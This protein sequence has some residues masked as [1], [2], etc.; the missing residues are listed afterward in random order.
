MFGAD[1]L[2]LTP[3]M[4]W[5]SWNSMQDSVTQAK[6][7]TAMSKLAEKRPWGLDGARASLADLGY[8]T[9][10]LDDAWQACGTGVNGSFHDGA[11]GRPLVNTSKFPEMGAMVAKAHALGLRAGFYINNCICAENMWRGADAFSTAMAA[12]VFEGTAAQVL[13][14]GFDGVKIDSCSQFS[15]MTR[16]AELFA[17]GPQT[18]LLEDCHDSDLQDPCPAALACPEK[19]GACPYSL[20]RTSGDIGANWP[21]MFHNL[22]LMLPWLGTPSLSRPGRW[23]YPDMMQVGQMEGG[24]LEDRAHFGAWC[25]CSA[26]LTLGHDV[27]DDALTRRIWGIVT[28]REAIAVNQAWAGHPGR[29]LRSLPSAQPSPPGDTSCGGYSCDTQ[30][31][32]KPLSATNGSTAVFLLANSDPAS[33]NASYAVD[34]AWL[35]MAGGRGATVRDVWRGADLGVVHANLT[36][37]AFGG[38]DSRFYIVTPLDP[39]SAAAQVPSPR[40]T[41]EESCLHGPA[42]VTPALELGHCCSG[43]N[44]SGQMPSCAMGCQIARSVPTF[45]ECAA[46]CTRAIGQCTFGPS[47]ATGGQTFNQCA[48]CIDGPGPNCATIFGINSSTP[49]VCSVQGFDKTCQVTRGCRDYGGEPASDCKQ[50]CLFTFGCEVAN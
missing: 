23:A 14:W 19:A 24:Q 6:M 42:G 18:V 7:E 31:W 3:P 33:P 36:T 11:T 34:L 21:S 50:A 44:S 26:P 40:R 37:D 39:P 32:V 29:V 8:G 49:S 2:A 30:L 20:W 17:G 15:N 38:H 43:T 5:R 16:W 47:A 46:T 4:G 1:T 9:V 12:R 28:N 48:N 10:G 35:G 25:V 45:D 27:T 22:Q 13:E 41:C